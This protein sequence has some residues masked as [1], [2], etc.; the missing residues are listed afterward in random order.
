MVASL[1]I[2][3]H[4]CIQKLVLNPIQTDLLERNETIISPESG[5]LEVNDFV[6]NPNQ[7]FE[8]FATGLCW[9]RRMQS[10]LTFTFGYAYDPG[11]G[12]RFIRVMPNYLEPLLEK[13][14]Q[15][16]GFWPNNCLL[17]YYPTGSHYISFHS[18]LGEEMKSGAGVAILSLGAVRTM[19]FRHIGNP[20]NQYFYSLKSGSVI[21]MKDEIQQSWEHAIL[22]QT[23]RGH[24]ISLSFRH[25]VN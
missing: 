3:I 7:W 1:S 4:S 12:L 22:K 13:I 6:K 2:C 19:V 25:L 14:N 10:R 23:G 5:I 24:R 8:H 15:L 16:F 20:D 18:D 17:N 21:Y 9:N 11:Y